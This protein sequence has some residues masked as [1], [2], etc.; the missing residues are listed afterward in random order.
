MSESPLVYIVFGTPQSGRREVIYDLID[1]GVPK[2]SQVLLFRPEGEC[3][4]SY[5][6][7]M[8]EL[9]NVAVVDWALNGAKITHGQVSAAPEI[10]IFLAPGGADPADVV[11][12]LKSWIE[13]NN[14]SLGRL[15]T[16]VNCAFLQEYPAAQSWYDAC[17]HFSDVILMN[18]RENNNNKWLTDFE[19]HHK[20]MCSPA[21][22][23]LVKKG[24]VPNP[25]EVLNPEA[26]RLSL[27][28]DELIPIEDDGLDEADQPEDTK[29]DKYIERLENGHRAY[30]VPSIQKYL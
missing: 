14:C 11:E 19:Q 29:P 4:S 22:F 27:Y 24:R 9:P 25:A 1:G 2:T 12:A 5:D 15:L 8:S 20:K 26:R 6:E 18:R 7:S 23:I 17:I 16:V 13:H 3:E 28:F 10:I 30:K 21:R